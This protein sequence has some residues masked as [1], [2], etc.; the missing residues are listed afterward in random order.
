MV[1]G[2]GASPIS[3]QHQRKRY[4]VNR[5][6]IVNTGSREIPIGPVDEN[7]ASIVVCA[8][9]RDWEKLESVRVEVVLPAQYR[10]GERLP[11]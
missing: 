2:F 9:A 11:A 10:D 4:D 8:L 5:M 7:T 1:S 6:V 3:T